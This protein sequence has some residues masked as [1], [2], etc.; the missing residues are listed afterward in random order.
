MSVHRIVVY[1][2]I[3]S[4]TMQILLQ[5]NT[6]FGCL[7]V[8]HCLHSH[9]HTAFCSSATRT[10]P[11]VQLTHLVDLKYSMISEHD[12]RTCWPC[13]F[14]KFWHLKFW[15]PPNPSNPASIA[16][17]DPDLA[18]VGPALFL[19]GLR[20]SLAAGGRI[21]RPLV[22]FAWK[23]CGMLLGHPPSLSQPDAQMNTYIYSYIYSY[24]YIVIYIVIYIN[25]Y[26]V[27][28]I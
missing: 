17:G 18:E 10:Q 19:R 9:P 24:I 22:F 5:V 20:F 26:I 25:I 13:F 6:I 12:F 14:S 21:Q 2:F 1:P 7:W 28:Y 16:R 27:I 15:N 4:Q 3:L 23:R 11:F 8:P